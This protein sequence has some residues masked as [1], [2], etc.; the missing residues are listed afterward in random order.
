MSANPKLVAFPLI[1]PWREEFWGLPL[2]FPDLI[3]GVLWHWP[4]GLPYQGRPLPSQIEL[5]LKELKHYAPGELTQWQAFEEYTAGGEELDDILRALRGEPEE[6]KRGKGPWET[7]DIHSLAWQLELAEADQEAH[8]NG[9][10]RGGQWLAEIFAPEPWE[11]EGTLPPI[12]GEPEILDAETARLRYL[13]W[14]REM[15]PHLESGAF[16]LLLGRTSRAIFASLRRKVG[17]APKT[18]VRLSLPGCRSASHC[19]RIRGPSRIPPWQPHFQERL[20]SCLLAA[21]KRDDP[22]FT[23]QELRRWVEIDLLNLWPEEPTCF[24]ELE[25]WEAAPEA[26]EGGEALL[27]WGSPGP[28][29]VAG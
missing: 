12:P 3:V 2:Y 16:P 23:A 20:K 22:G 13:L 10:D 5:S 19:Q 18:M 29:I 21:H 8:L 9:V 7:E 26:E 17:A 28:P 27:V 6:E 25:I 4:P 14:R 1:L 24:T 15:K 11:K